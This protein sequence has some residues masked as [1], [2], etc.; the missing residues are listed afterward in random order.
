[1]KGNHIGVGWNR[2][3]PADWAAVSQQVFDGLPAHKS[4]HDLSGLRGYRG[5][6]IY[7]VDCGEYTKIGFTSGH[8][9]LRLANLATANPYP[10]SLWAL[11]RGNWRSERSFHQQLKHLSHRKEWFRLTTEARAELAEQIRGKGGEVYD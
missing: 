7:F 6:L 1:M 3:D 9:H 10:M 11:V 5:G 8:V 2:Y 4:R